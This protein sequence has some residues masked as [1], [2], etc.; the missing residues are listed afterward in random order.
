[1]KKNNYYRFHELHYHTN[2]CAKNISHTDE[3]L[4]NWKALI[5]SYMAKENKLLLSIIWIYFLNK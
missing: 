3:K 1:M 4:L 5:I 2:L